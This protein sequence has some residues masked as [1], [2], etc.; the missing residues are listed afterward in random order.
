MIVKYSEIRE[1]ISVGDIIGCQGQGLFARA[2]RLFKGGEW[3]L[4]H[5][6]PIVSDVG[7]GRVEVLEA[8]TK[9]G[10]QRNFLSKIYE[11]AHGTLFWIPMNCSEEQKRKIVNLGVEVLK[12]KVKY[13]FRATYFAIFTQILMDD[14]EFNC[15]EFA[16]WMLT[17]AGRLLKRLDKKGREIAPVP[18]NL[19]T[20]AG[21]EPIQIGMAG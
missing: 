18:G 16:W 10:I 20:W 4:S 2:I 9:P 14:E 21:V 11:K 17:R 7:T 6:A 5:I 1:Q 19:P 3:D 13:D 8:L 15:S 12:K